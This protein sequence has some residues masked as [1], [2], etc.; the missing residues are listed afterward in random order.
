MNE[1]S[2]PIKQL[3]KSLRPILFTSQVLFYNL[4]F[5]FSKNFSK[6]FLVKLSLNI[7][8]YILSGNHDQFL[9]API[10]TDFF[11]ILVNDF[12]ANIDQLNNRANDAD[13]SNTTT[14]MNSKGQNAIPKY[15]RK[16]FLGTNRRN[17]YKA[18]IDT[19]LK[20]YILIYHPEMIDMTN[21]TDS[22]SLTFLPS[23]WSSLTDCL[24][25]LNI[26]FNSVNTFSQ[27][28]SIIIGQIYKQCEESASVSLQESWDFYHTHINCYGEFSTDRLF[29][30]EKYAEIN[31]YCAD[32]L[33]NIYYYGGTFFAG[34]RQNAY[35]VKS[36]YVKAAYYYK[37]CTKEPN[38]IVSACWSLGYMYYTKR[39][40][41]RGMDNISAAIELFNKC[42]NYPPALNSLGVIE[43]D[44][45]D[46]MRKRTDYFLLDVTEKKE[47]LR[48]YISYIEKCYSACC[49]G[50]VYAYNNLYDFFFKKENGQILMDLKEEEN[51][52]ELDPLVLLERAAAL[53]NY[54]SMDMLAIHYIANYLYE[55]PEIEE[56]YPDKKDFFLLVKQG[57]VTLKA[58]GLNPDKKLAPKLVEAR[59][60]LKELDLI[61]YDRG[62]FHLAM[63]FYF[64][65]PIMATLLKKASD[66]G[67][68]FARDA[69]SSILREFY[70]Y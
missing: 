7:D 27:L 65:K 25:I 16:Q 56:K 60:M 22:A 55:F 62:S 8:N 54:W 37:L 67:N 23:T 70:S 64:D 45:A 12:N 19:V 59:N 24:S 4:L 38:I 57:K 1:I 26:P 6:D 40:N 31:V 2:T 32:E 47:I 30:L 34:G 9:N 58:I 51:F 61:N 35:E 10:S 63:N 15:W 29:A 43:R 50:W 46:D 69:L 11:R 49:N 52:F 36:D 18:C 13:R 20:Y 39:I 53:K 66:Q 42:G 48:H 5:E 17:E 3:Y 44:I 21:S 33:A 28:T 14:R 41:P 68:E